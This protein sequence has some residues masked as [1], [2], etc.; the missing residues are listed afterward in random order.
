[1]YLFLDDE[2]SPDQ[3][4]IPQR[5]DNGSEIEWTV[6]KNAHECISFLEKGNVKW[7]SLD[8]DLGIGAYNGYDVVHW[9]IEQY[10]TNPDFKF[11]EEI[12]I[13]TMNP[14]AGDDMMKSLEKIGLHPKKA[15]LMKKL[16]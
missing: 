13:H 8:H 15:F 9:L 6:V 12:W 5:F 4:R 2:R 11:P 16:R 1:M 3:V 10:H 7:L 14:Y